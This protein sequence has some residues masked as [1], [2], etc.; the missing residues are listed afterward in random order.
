MITISI[1]KSTFGNRLIIDV[2][3][4]EDRGVAYSP[5]PSATFATSLAAAIVLIPD[6]LTEV[7][8]DDTAPIVF[9]ATDV[10]VDTN[11]LV[12]FHQ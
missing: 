8:V 9:E 10:S 1:D 6:T 3:A 2:A 12:T 5:T 7:T 11:R 4:T